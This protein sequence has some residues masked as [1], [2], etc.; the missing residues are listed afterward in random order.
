MTTAEHQALA[1]S[2]TVVGIPTHGYIEHIV[3]GPLH[4]HLGHSKTQSTGRALCGVQGSNGYWRTGFRVIDKPL[5]E[6]GC[7]KCLKILGQQP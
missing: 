6:A 2:E 5:A 7:K 3:R 1:A 4:D